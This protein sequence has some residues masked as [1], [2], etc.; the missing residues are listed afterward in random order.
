[1]LVP[2]HLASVFLSYAVIGLKPDMTVNTTNIT[3]Y[4]ATD[5]GFLYN[6]DRQ[7]GE[8]NVIG[9]YTILNSYQDIF[10]FYITISYLD[11]LKQSFFPISYSANIA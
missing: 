6:I 7:W 2:E 9:R 1:M 8:P 3:C 11:T 10:L 5:R 4:T